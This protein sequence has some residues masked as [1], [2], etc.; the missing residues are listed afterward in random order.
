MFN[1]ILRFFNTIKFLKLKQINY[2]L[3][4]LIRSKF[5]KVVGIKPLLSINSY[6]Y[7]LQL[8][9]SIHIIDS[10]LGDNSFCFL[11]LLKKFEKEIDWNYA[12]Y[13][14]LWRYNLTYFDFLSQNHK[15]SLFL[16]ENFIDNNIQDG[17]EPFPISLRGINWIKYISYHNIKNKKIDNSLYA[18]YYILLDTLEYH[19][20]G[21]H[22]LENA[23]SLLFGAYY[24]QDEKFYNSAKIILLE[25]LEEQILDDGGHFE[26]SPMYHQIMLFRV[27]DC[28]NLIKNN[29]W[30]ER[31]LLEFLT[32]KAE[33]MF[34]WLKAI[35]YKNGDI[36]LLNDSANCIAPTT[37]QLFKYFENLNLRVENLK[38]SDSGY[39][40]IT[41]DRYECVVDIGNIGAEYIAG[42]AHADTFSFELRIDGKPFIVDTGISTYESCNRRDIE[43]STTSHNTVEV[44]GRNQSEVWGGFR[45]ANRANIIDIKELENM[46]ESTHNGYRNILHTRQWIFDKDSIIIRDN[47]TQEAKAIARLHFHPNITKEDISRYID[48]DDSWEFGEYFY[49]PEF[50]IKLTAIVVVIKFTNYLEIN[51]KCNKL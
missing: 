10:Y 4:Y 14:K 46:I 27:L 34:G 31:E 41:K 9:N 47:L 8:Q 2:R 39:R 42:H 11:N 48:I 6:T 7:P 12:N 13:G 33:K 38:L 40:K 18:Q 19:L 50:N 49:S 35:S 28:I 51:I 21:N 45:V 36:P 26:L 37:D 3:Y 29:S 17:L 1:K 25:Q 22:L 43:R 44:N 5:R 15:D 32:I 30:K 23:F 16:I 24:F 20:L